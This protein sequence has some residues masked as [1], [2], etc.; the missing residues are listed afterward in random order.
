MDNMGVKT[1]AMGEVPFKELHEIIRL[2]G[3][4][5]VS[6]G[7][8]HSNQMLITGFINL[9]IAPAKWLE[10]T[11]FMSFPQIS[12]DFLANCREYQKALEAGHGIDKS[13]PGLSMDGVSESFK[14]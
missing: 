5:V 4:R 7:V 6:I 2:A 8:E 13:S 11:D 10:Q 14:P 3:Y 12:P 9:Q 1:D